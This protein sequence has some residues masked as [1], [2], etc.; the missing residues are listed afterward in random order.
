MN[1]ARF[2]PLSQNALIR[3]RKTTVTLHTRVGTIRI[4]SVYGQDPQTGQR[5]CPLRL[6]LGVSASVSATPE[7]KE[8]LCFIATL[9]LSYE[10]AAQIADKMGLSVNDSMIHRYVAEVGGKV[11]ALREREIERAIEP[12]TRAEVIRQAKRDSQGEAFSLVIMLD[13]WMIRERGDQWGLKPR[14]AAAQERVAWREMK[15]G[16]VFRVQDQ[17]RTQSGRGMVLKKYHEAWRGEAHDFGR[18]LYALALRHGLHQAQRVFVVADGGVWIWKIAGERFAGAREVLDFYHASEH[19]HAVARAVFPN[20]DQA[21]QWV[22]PLLH[23]LKH[24]GEAGVI[25]TLEQLVGLIDELGAEQAETV[26]KNIAYFQA[27]RDRLSYA[28]LPSHGC[29]IGSGAMESTC[30]QLQDRFKRTGQFWVR[31]GAQALMA[32][33][34]IRRNE[35]WEPYMQSLW[36]Q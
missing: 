4:P 13:G 2:P 32:L 1:K 10:A 3:K 28:D 21:H 33:E 7:L 9:S 35:Q 17:A 25:E 23:Q 15:T 6:R 26:T 31:P 22:E 14:E 18:R 36:S 16:I 24:G 20:E 11:E 29:P 12:A 27:N 34:L 5:L 19:L 8:L 30:A